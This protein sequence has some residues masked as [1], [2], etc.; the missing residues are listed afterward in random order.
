MHYEDPFVDRNARL[1]VVIYKHETGDNEI[2]DYEL[3]SIQECKYI[4]INKLKDFLNPESED[5]FEYILNN[6]L[7]RL[8]PENSYLFVLGIKCGRITYKRHKK[9]TT[10][11]LKKE[12]Y[13]G[14]HGWVE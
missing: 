11:R 3:S 6:R 2:F 12:P 5:Y 14:L 13:L 1:T 7:E 10:Q 9:I 4:P 8:R